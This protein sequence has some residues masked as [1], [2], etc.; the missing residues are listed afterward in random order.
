MSIDPTK[1]RSGSDRRD[2]YTSTI[3]R[4]HDASGDELEGILRSIR[5][6]VLNGGDLEAAAAMDYLVGKTLRQKV[7]PFYKSL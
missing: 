4:L 5:T 1:S 3:E 6:R 7:F 2:E